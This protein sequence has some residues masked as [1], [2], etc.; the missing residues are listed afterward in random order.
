MTIYLFRLRCKVCMAPI[1]IRVSSLDNYIIK[2]RCLS[3]GATQ[4]FD[5]RQ[6]SYVVI[7]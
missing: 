5:L 1:V 7:E 2:H 4:S 6:Y 3:C